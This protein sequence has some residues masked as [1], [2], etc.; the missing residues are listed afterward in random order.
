MSWGWGSTLASSPQNC[1][2]LDRERFTEFELLGVLR[3][4]GHPG[5]VL[6]EEDWMRHWE[7][8]LEQAQR[9]Q[10]LL[11]VLDLLLFLGSLVGHGL[12]GGQDY[13]GYNLLLLRL[14]WEN[15]YLYLNNRVDVIRIA[16]F[17]SWYLS[18][19]VVLAW[20]R[21]KRNSR[22]L[23]I[24]LH[25]VKPTGVML[26]NL[27]LFRLIDVL[28]WRPNLPKL[29]GFPLVTPIKLHNLLNELPRQPLSSLTLL[30]FIRK[31]DNFILQFCV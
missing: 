16:V 10:D 6:L 4:A 24:L 22:H 13:W 7:V 20:K 18:V 27:H 1:R 23:P 9:L 31:H 15:G 5:C 29:L 17:L 25:K 28:I 19:G 12:V 11:A 3:F 30:I 8:V 2:R 26:L 14:C 21:R